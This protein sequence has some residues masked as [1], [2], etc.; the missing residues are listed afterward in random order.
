MCK[1][2]PTE[3]SAQQ[4]ICSSRGEYREEVCSGP[5]MHSRSPVAFVRGYHAAEDGGE[6]RKELE[7]S[8][9]ETRLK[10]LDTGA[11]A[12]QGKRGCII[13]VG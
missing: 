3:G 1:H 2:E 13:Q 9:K 11:S 5:R 10:K 12:T 8:A 6:L 7:T 4:Y